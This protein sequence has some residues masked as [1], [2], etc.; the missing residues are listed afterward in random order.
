MAGDDLHGRRLGGFELIE[1]LGEGSFG[2]VWRARQLR[3][4]R[5]VAVKVLDPL[6]A[7]DPTAARRFEREGRA[8]ASLDHPSI[9]PVYEAGDDDGLYYLAMRLVDGET[10][11]DVIDRDAPMSAASVADVLRPIGDALDAAHANGLIHRDV[12][13]ANILIEDGRPY[14]SD[15]GIAAS[16]R[17]LGRYTTGSIGTA[18]YMAPEQ[19]RGDSVDH[20]S[21][22]YALGCVAFHA[23][24]GRSP[25]ARDDMVSTLLAHSVD[26]VPAT[27]DAGLDAFFARA[28]AKAPD[29]RFDS[30][31]DLVAALPTESAGGAAPVPGS[32]PQRR[33]VVALAA[34][35]A[36][37]VAGL[38]VLA[39]RRADAPA[40]DQAI[41][42]D[43]ATTDQATDATDPTDD[44]VPTTRAASVE[45]T[46]PPTSMPV[47]ASTAV[48]TEPGLPVL[49]SGGSVAVGT[50]LD[51]SDPNPHASLDTAKLF[52]GSV[53]P[54]MYTIDE[55]LDPSP[56]L[57]VGPPVAG[58]DPL[59]LSWSIHDDRVWHDGEPVTT[60]DI[61][62]TFEYLT[63]PDTNAAN[64]ALYD[65]V[66]AVRAVDD[67][68]LEIELGA[69]NGAA[70][71]MFSTI[72]PIVSSS[73]WQGHLEGGGTAATFLDDGVGFAAGPYQLATR[74]N[75]GEIA[76]ARNPAWT[77]TPPALDRVAFASYPDSSALVEAQRRREVDMIWVDDVERTEVLDAAAL[78]DIDIVV[79][80]A[81]IAVQL[82]MNLR[83]EPLADPLVR[84]AILHAL[85]R[86]LIA[87]IA[88][89]RKTGSVASSWNSLV[90]APAQRG[91]AQP[92]A[93]L[94]DVEE[95]ERLLDEAG[96]VRPDDS[97]F[98]RKNGEDL[99][100]TLVLTADSDSINTALAVESA[101]QDI[102]I[103]IT[104]TPANVTLTNE[105]LTTGAFD[106]LLQYRIL[107]SDPVATEFSFAA[108]ACPATIEGCDG[109]GVNVGAYRDDELDAAFGR[110]AGTSDPDER[111]AAFA[112]IDT[113]LLAGV[114]AVPLYVEPAFTAF[115]DD[116][117]GVTVAPTLG[118]IV[119]V[120]E[121]GFLAAE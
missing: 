7:R 86:D 49:R 79:G 32:R 15:F 35:A 58:G 78:D 31:A 85:D 95:A 1:P 96:W 26:D 62:A 42:G 52:A 43:G 65:D 36:V 67:V 106:L 30:A 87:D 38:V 61:V 116:I 5:D 99:A 100:F 57:A 44:P 19:A 73:A 13:P 37:L 103:D 75:P 108:T 92:F 83:S 12:K 21:D 6:V 56:S 88:V 55:Q 54:V 105:R 69:P 16:T 45:P 17:E 84:R 4:D 25:F 74:Q 3:L 76:F 91:N 70:Y 107:N 59:V 48:T 60:D 53:L 10:L 20:R 109:S 115:R 33:H 98:R 39:G 111:S 117:G 40:D 119:S 46:T 66:V 22:V 112:D 41:P 9:V 34:V 47:P 101:L 51:L 11:A 63:A 72:H 8:A 64:T 27:G 28:L 113:M 23:I 102:G 18:E 90:F 118:P 110:A 2:S 81:D 114:P 24:T 120:A 14:L 121:W 104:G 71:L 68:T 94:H 77:G 50:S 82:T 80:D 29:D 93:D 89:G 97:V